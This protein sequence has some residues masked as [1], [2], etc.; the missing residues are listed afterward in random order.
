LTSAANR[1]EARYALSSTLVVNR[2][3]HTHTS[4]ALIN[5]PRRSQRGWSRYCC[6]SPSLV[7]KG[8]DMSGWSGPQAPLGIGSTYCIKIVVMRQ[9]TLHGAIVYCG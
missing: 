8:R 4:P 1:N 7:A 5:N 6:H 9:G 2:T 3:T